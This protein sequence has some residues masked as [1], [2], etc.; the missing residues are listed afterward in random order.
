M[1]DEARKAA[2]DDPQ[3]EADRAA[4]YQA[5]ADGERDERLAA[6]YRKLAAVEAAHAEMQGTAAA[7]SLRAGLLARIGRRL[8]P[9]L[10]LPAIAPGCRAPPPAT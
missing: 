8:G 10:V 4:I 5:L 3:A 9:T 7:A 1:P 2:L 6:V